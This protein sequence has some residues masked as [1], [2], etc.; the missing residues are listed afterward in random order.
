MDLA[1]SIDDVMTSF[2][3]CTGRWNIVGFL[4][5]RRYMMLTISDTTRRVIIISASVPIIL[6]VSTMYACK[7]PPP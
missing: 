2:A 4:T 7:A 3:Q 5:E 6:A 1:V